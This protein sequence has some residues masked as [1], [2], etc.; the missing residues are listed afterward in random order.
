MRN[1]YNVVVI[2]STEGSP[3]GEQVLDMIAEQQRF[4]E[5]FAPGKSLVT[6]F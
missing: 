6:R 2:A 1:Y 3:A 5:G 4:Q